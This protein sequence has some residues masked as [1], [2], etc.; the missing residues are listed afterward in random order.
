LIRHHVLGEKIEPRFAYRNGVIM[1][2]LQETFIDR[3][4]FP[5][6]PESV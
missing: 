2:G 3:T 5:R 1:R 4:D 6:A